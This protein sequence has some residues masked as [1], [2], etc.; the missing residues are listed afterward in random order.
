MTYYV[1]NQQITTFD[2]DVLNKIA[3]IIFNF[4]SSK[5][6]GTMILELKE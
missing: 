1:H 2:N 3:L 4:N 5:N 6:N